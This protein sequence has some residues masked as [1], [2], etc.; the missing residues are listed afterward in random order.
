MKS[1]HEQVESETLNRVRDRYESKGYRF[2]VKPRKS[3]VPRFLVGFEPDAIALKGKGG[4]VI[5]VKSSE[6]AAT[7]SSVVDFLAREVPKHKGWRF[8]LVLADKEGIEPSESLQPSKREILASVDKVSR[9]V[10]EGSLQAALLFAWSLLE[11]ATR[12]MLLRKQEDKRFLPRTIVEAIATN[13]FVSNEE[14]RNLLEIAKLRNWLIHGFTRA[15][16]YRTQIDLLI[17]IVQR[18]LGQTQNL[19]RRSRRK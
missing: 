1:I 12:L 10:E 3:D 15:V 17:E 18:V 6:K 2:L 9:M 7:R 14:E 13:A 8:D 5:E 4:V 19:S 16:V 11:A